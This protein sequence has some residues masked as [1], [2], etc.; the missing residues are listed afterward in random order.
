M[1]K[2]LSTQRQGNLLQFYLL[3]NSLISSI[4]SHLYEKTCF[5]FPPVVLERVS[6]MAS[7]WERVCHEVCRPW[8]VTVF[9]HDSKQNKDRWRGRK[10]PFVYGFPHFLILF[11]W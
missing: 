10:L 2:L 3:Y 4:L 5:N 6:N 11:Y 8:Q 1:Y 9:E 7:G